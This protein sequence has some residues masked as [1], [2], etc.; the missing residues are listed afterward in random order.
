[1]EAQSN[2]YWMCF[3]CKYSAPCVYKFI[4]ILDIILGICVFL[5]GLMGLI[6]SQFKGL[7]PWVT[8]LVGC[9]FLYMA[10]LAIRL[11]M[12]YSNNLSSGS[13]HPQTDIYLKVRI[14]MVYA[15]IVL[16]ILI[17]ILIVVQIMLIADG[18]SAIIAVAIYFAVSILIS[19]GINAWTQWTFQKSLTEANDVL[20]GTTSNMPKGQLL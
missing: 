14:F 11:M 15:Y 16:A 6:Q 17:P 2:L 13:I 5:Q 1:M 8:I 18:N 19:L 9:Y 7:V 12:D 20:G 10:Y 3:T 4:L